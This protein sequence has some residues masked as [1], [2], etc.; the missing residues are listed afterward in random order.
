MI[1][2]AVYFGKSCVPM[3]IIAGLT[4][5][6]GPSLLRQPLTDKF[7]EEKLRLPFQEPLHYLSLHSQELQFEELQLRSL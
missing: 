5:E 2:R 7:T 4:R 6:K 3:L 1:A